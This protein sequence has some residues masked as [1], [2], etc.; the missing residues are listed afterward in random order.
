MQDIAPDWSY[1]AVPA[2]RVLNCYM[3]VARYRGGVGYDG[4]VPVDTGSWGLTVG[5]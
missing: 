2:Q 1:D 3:S 5:I 4:D